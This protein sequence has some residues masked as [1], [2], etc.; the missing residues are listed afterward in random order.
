MLDL[1]SLNDK[2]REAV[3]RTDGPLLV[4]AGAGSG[5][6]RTLT[7]RIA[8]I[9]E[10]GLAS[11]HSILAI[12]FT[13]KAAWEI[14]R[15]I[16][17][18]VGRSAEDVT[19]TT[20][21]SLAFKLLSAE[22]GTLGFN[23]AKLK[24][25]DG[26]E[27]RRRLARAVKDIGLDTA[28][29]SLDDLAHTLER[30]KDNLY[31]PTDFVR[32]PGDFYEESIAKV[33]ARYQQLLHERNAVDYGDL[34]RLAVE[35]LRSNASTLTFYQNLF[36]Y[37]SIDEFQDT[38]FAQYQLV[39]YLVWRNQNICCVGSPVQTIYTWRGADINNILN[40]FRA[41]FPNAPIIGLR[42]NYRSTATILDAA[43][44]VVG[45]LPYRDEDLRAA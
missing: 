7:Y 33:Y 36:R 40:R 27:T 6:T 43:Q 32:V 3:D 39:R 19:A 41:D 21:H 9:L 30:A 12:T 24:V 28:R 15:R 16:M 1:G 14:R 22:G 13:R 23:P 42:D 44:A 29:W 35:L 18:L 11:P 4:L 10:R 34:I 2:Q 38:S 8:N 5:K 20:F 25:L 17:E 37:V 31:A 26:S 45:D